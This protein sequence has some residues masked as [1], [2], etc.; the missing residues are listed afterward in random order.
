MRLERPTLL[1][2]ALMP[3]ARV[4]VILLFAYLYGCFEVR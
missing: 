1:R 3:R 2:P 4:R